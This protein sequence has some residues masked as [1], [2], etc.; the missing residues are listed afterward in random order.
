MTTQ[1]DSM[2]NYFLCF[3]RISVMGKASV[4][5]GK[6]SIKVKT[7]WAEP[8]WQLEVVRDTRALWQIVVMAGNM[9]PYKLTRTR[10]MS[11][12]REWRRGYLTLLNVMKDA[13]TSNPAETERIY[14]NPD[15]AGNAERAKNPNLLS[16]LRVD[17][18]S[19][20]KFIARCYG[21]EN[22]PAG[23]AELLRFKL[24]NSPQPSGVSVGKKELSE[25]AEL[26][27]ERKD[28]SLANATKT[29][30]RLKALLFVSQLWAIEKV[31]SYSEKGVEAEAFAELKRRVAELKL[32][33]V[34]GFGT[35]GLKTLTE[36]WSKAL[37]EALN[38]V[39][40]DEKQPITN[41]SM[42]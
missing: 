42:G 14:F 10:R 26:A 29:I 32:Y 22:M 13:L 16:E 6:R 9:A 27:R 5:S 11:A 36:G 25:S 20:L 8:D 7:Q 33:R 41:P 21:A 34:E 18:L 35:G 3:E 40:T 38:S 28:Q 15:H 2:E 30:N 19:A 12:D 31:T 39:K 1:S 17:T 24:S 37:S 23:M 4:G